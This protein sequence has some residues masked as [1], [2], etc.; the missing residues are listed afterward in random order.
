MVDHLQAGRIDGFC[1]GEPWNTAA[2]SSGI[3]QVVTNAQAIWP[4][5]ADKVLGV[6]QAWAQRYPNTHRALVAAI[7]KAQHELATQT[8]YAELIK[9]LEQLNVLE[10]P[11]SWLNA[12]LDGY[13]AGNPARFL[14]GLNARP[15]PADYAWVSLQIVRWQQWQQ[16]IDLATLSLQSCDMTCFDEAYAFLS[17][18][19]N[20]PEQLSP[21]S[22]PKH[23]ID[24][25]QAVSYLISKGWTSQAAKKI[26]M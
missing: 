25:R 19:E 16:P 18:Q 12:A 20:L 15:K 10:L 13:S 21:S 23:T 26:L 11:E 17:Q 6:T 22:L 4:H 24:T 7:L 8:Y 1:V 9:I 3:G 2:V 5:G 14:T